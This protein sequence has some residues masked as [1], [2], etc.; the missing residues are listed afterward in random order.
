MTRLS[1]RFCIFAPKSQ[2]M[3]SAKLNPALF[4]EYVDLEKKIGHKFRKEAGSG[5]RAGG[6]PGRGKH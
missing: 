5:G 2:L 1:C 3:L 4:Q 6:R